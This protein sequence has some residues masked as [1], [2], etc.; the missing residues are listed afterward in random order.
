MSEDVTIVER[1]RADLETTWEAE[2]WLVGGVVM[3][4]PHVDQEFA[5]GDKFPK[6]WCW[7]GEEDLNHSQLGGGI[8]KVYLPVLTQIVFQY[9]QT[10]KNQGLRQVGYRILGKAQVAIMRDPGR[11]KFVDDRKNA[12][13][14]LEQRTLIEMLPDTNF[15]I[16]HME[17]RVEYNR[18]FDDPTRMEPVRLPASL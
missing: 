10:K 1:I 14:T 5:K 18:A 13:T 16:V 15:G 2:T 11:G 3:E 17:H 9:D 7:E 12:K 6:A 8:F 4:E